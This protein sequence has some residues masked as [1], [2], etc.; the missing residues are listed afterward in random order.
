MPTYLHTQTGDVQ[1]CQQAL[2]PVNG[3]SAS[4]PP[5]DVCAFIHYVHALT[6]ELLRVQAKE[7]AYPFH[8]K[9]TVVEAPA[10]RERRIA[11][12]SEV[13]CRPALI[14]YCCR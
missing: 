1:A 6:A 12:G 5:P 10:R 11:Y 4:C 7:G 13:R 3:L 2:E 8:D 14:L 9:T